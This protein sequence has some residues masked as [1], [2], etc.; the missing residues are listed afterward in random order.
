MG[1]SME[2]V[3]SRIEETAGLLKSGQGQQ[4]PGYYG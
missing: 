3:V 4:D 2:V 1:G